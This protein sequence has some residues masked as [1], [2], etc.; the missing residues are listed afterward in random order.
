MNISTYDEIFNQFGDFQ[1]NVI[2]LDH[3]FSL[4]ILSYVV[5]I[6]LKKDLGS[7]GYILAN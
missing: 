2:F 7:K 6:M 3:Q 1:E 4:E 5:F